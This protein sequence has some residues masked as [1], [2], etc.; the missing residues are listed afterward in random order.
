M[1][2]RHRY[3]GPG[4]LG[5]DGHDATDFD[6]R[7]PHLV[8]GVDPGSADE[9]SGDGV[10]PEQCAANE[11]ASAAGEDDCQHDGH[12]CA[13][14]PIDLMGVPFAESAEFRCKGRETLRGVRRYPV[15]ARRLCRA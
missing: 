4:S 5:H 3:P 14:G 15:A 11:Q 2:D 13:E 12:G 6:A 8:T 10:R 1:L 9:L 7:H